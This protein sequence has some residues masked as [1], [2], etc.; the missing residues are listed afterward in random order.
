[1]Y[2]ISV[3]TN[4]ATIGKLIKE[5]LLG[6]ARVYS[7]NTS[8]ELFD[9]LQNNRTDFLILDRTIGK[10]SAKDIIKNIE[11]PPE[12]LL[13]VS[14]KYNKKIDGERYAFV[15]RKPFTSD[16]LK[17]VLSY[18][19]FKNK[20]NSNKNS[21]I[22][23]VDDSDISRQ[24]IKSK[25]SLMGYD[26]LEASNGKDAI[27]VLNEY[28]KDISLIITDHE[29]PEITGLEFAKQVRMSGLYK[30][31]PIIMTTSLYED[32]ALRKKAFSAGINE[33]LPKPFED[34]LL[35]NAINNFLR[36]SQNFNNRIILI[37][38]LN[39]RRRAIASIVKSLGFYIFTTNKADKF[40]NLIEDNEF[41]L[42]LV[43][44]I[45]EDT[46]G[47]E[48]IKKLRKEMSITYP[49]IIY[50]AFDNISA[51]KKLSEIYEA[52]ANDYLLAPFE[53]E[54]LVFKIKTWIN[55]HNLFKDAKNKEKML[56][57]TLTYDILTEVYNRFNILKKGEEHFSLAKRKNLP[58]SIL[59]MDI[60]YF[61]S[62]NDKYGHDI[63]DL[64]L[65][66]FAKTINENIR[67]EDSFGRIGGE[68]FLAVLPVT[69]KKDAFKVAEK[70][71]KAVENITFDE[72]P[73]LKITVS[74]G[75][76]SLEKDEEI[77]TF[78]KLILIADS[79]LYKAKESG[80]N[81]VVSQ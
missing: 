75:I 54:E 44:Y 66:K 7:F 41:D 72:I 8:K 58:F 10:E 9:Y 57:K 79:M 60:D 21:Y 47:L 38:D 50:T 29:M 11:N 56:K 73:K 71:R 77:T 67:A 48:L 30:D 32:L 18:I 20:Y 39:T 36:I 5:M 16:E 22:L 42:A 61:K 12:T 24:I 4:T 65:K 45:L 63:G 34:T 31:I 6:F 55:Y 43:D 64:V 68:E 80:R 49:I 52:G 26:I 33:F 14:D 59:Y 46:T 51:K 27:N 15:L 70:L 23:L 19:F 78:D 37:D 81:R 40:L 62:I 25:V 74:I 53:T 69:D 28:Q 35:H 1:M 13:L 2:N 3:L 17:E 76:S